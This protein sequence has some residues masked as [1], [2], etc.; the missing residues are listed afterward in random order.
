MLEVVTKVKENNCRKFM[1]QS[2]GP[3]RR[4]MAAPYMRVRCYYC[5]R[6]GHIHIN[7][8]KRKRDL[9]GPSRISLGVSQLNV[10]AN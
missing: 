10:N 3:G 6:P 7:Y 1:R 4:V 8:F 5:N 9:G 2:P